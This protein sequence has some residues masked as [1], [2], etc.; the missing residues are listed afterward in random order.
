MNQAT[1]A[2]KR[3]GLNSLARNIHIIYVSKGWYSK[4][5]SPLEFHML[6]IT[7]LAE[8]TEEVRKG[9]PDL[10]QVKPVG[11]ND[12]E[13]YNVIP[14]DPDWDNSG[15]SKPEGE[16]IE[17]IGTLIRLLD[18]CAHRDWDIERLVEMKMSY[19]ATRAHRHGGK[20]F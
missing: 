12:P 10:Y 17:I 1:A 16:S 9:A 5:R 2:L 18:Y 14:G 4:S 13:N 15:L 11:L 6:M 3:S 19:N 7:E 20:V 8:A